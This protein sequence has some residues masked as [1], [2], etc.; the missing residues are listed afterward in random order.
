[1][2][3]H[4][5]VFTKPL[6]ERVRGLMPDVS[7]TERQALEAGDVWWDADLF[8]G[9][10]DWNRLI[11]D[12]SAPALSDEE[13]AFLDGQV[14]ELCRMIDDWRISFE[15][16]SLPPELWD[17]LREHKFFGMIIP[18]EYGGLGFSAAAHSEVVSILATRSV[19][20]AVTVMVPNS[21]GPGELLL[22]YGTEAQRDYYLPRLADGREIPS[23]GLTSP[24]AGSD[25]SAI[26]DSG[27]VC[28]GEYRGERVLGMR[29]NWHKRYITLGPVATLLGLA[30]RLYDPDGLLGDEENLGITL[31]LVPT[32]TP[33][34]QIGR[35]HI[36]ALQAF[37]N[38][39]NE[40][41]DVFLPL[42]AIIGG[43]AQIG[44]GWEMLMSALS[45]GRS[46]SLP[47]MSTGLAKL[48]ARSTGAY[49]RIREQFGLPVGRFEGVQEAMGRIA[50]RTYELDA[51]RRV[52]ARAVDDGCTPSVIS[53]I[54]KS[55]STYRVRDVMRDA[56]DVH[57]GKMVCDGPA[58]YLGNAYRS[59]PV[60]ITVEGSNILTR[61]LIVFGQGALRCH[62]YLREEIAAAG[63]ADPDKAVEQFDRVVWRHVA[64]TFGNLG[65]AFGHAVTA[66][67]FAR[68]PRE[69]GTAARFYRRLS[70]YSA[71]LAFVSEIALMSLGGA[72]KRKEM[73]SA[74]LGDV[75]SELYLLSCVLKRFHDEGSLEEDL[76]LVTWCCETGFAKIERSFDEVCRNYPGRALAFLMRFAALPLGLR[77]RG[78]TDALTKRCADMLMQPN[79]ARERL[80]RGVF[81]GCEG[82][83]LERVEHAF[84]Q[85]VGTDGI[86]RRMRNADL[87]DP[88]L[89]LERGVISEPECRALKK[90]RDAVAAAIAVDD[91]DPAQLSPDTVRYEE[92]EIARQRVRGHRR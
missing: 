3:W 21:L 1:M 52:T 55:E 51:A 48:A 23:F 41:H 5:R 83:G 66:S 18:R 76:P 39:P 53:A 78:P 38:G 2:K 6:F 71:A 56:M 81:R 59:M 13:Q 33:G 87:D 4:T 8:S 16:R 19:T 63:E 11:H 37:Q 20:V 70:R 54:L 45:A 92:E 46:I 14:A 9:K 68:Q 89:A 44:H 80:T 10:P 75:L 69:A 36:P 85:V 65:R 86:R 7:E 82:E 28:H 91:F 25:A 77:R 29:L 26:T 30:F 34:V 57:G 43:Q 79:A 35:R 64:A 72:L 42:S 84:D 62:P 90:T 24:E 31:A 22:E 61:N 88:D 47:G 67:R 32:T 40:G 17:F 50:G 12:T 49:A 74:R 27:I 60:A 58:N 73:I 15:L